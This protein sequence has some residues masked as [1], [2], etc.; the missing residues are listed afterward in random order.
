MADSGSEVQKGGRRGIYSVRRLPN[1]VSM[2]RV[3]SDMF[4]DDHDVQQILKNNG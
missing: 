4:G 3:C 2:S 1:I